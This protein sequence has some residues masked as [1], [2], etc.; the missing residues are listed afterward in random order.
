MC[1]QGQ[2]LR[3]P[4]STAEALAMAHAAADYLNGADLASLPGQAQA[5]ALI[6]LGRLAA[7][8]TAAH[9]R[10]VSAFAAGGGPEAD[11][12]YSAKTWLRHHTRITRGAA[13]AYTAW[14]RRLS[15]HPDV[16]SALAGGQLS[17]SWARQLC[18][19]TGRLPEQHRPAADEIL[20][21]AVRT[22]AALEDLAVLAEAIY[23]RVCADGPEADADRAFRDRAVYLGRTIGGA[24]RLEGDLTPGAAAALSAVLEALGAPSGP[25]DRRSLGQRNHDALAEGCRRLLAEGT[26]PARAG[27]G[28]RAE[29]AISLRQLRSL[30]GADAAE[31]GWVAAMT[32]GSGTDRTDSTDSTADGD[33]PYSGTL[34]GAEAAAAACDA[35]VVPVVYGHVDTGALEQMADLIL[36]SRA[37]PC[38]TGT[39]PPEAGP[40]PAGTLA[41]ATR[42]RLRAAL[43]RWAIEVLSGPGG[44]AAHLRRATLGEELASISLPLDVGQAS[45]I[46]PAHI[47]RAVIAR[48]RHCRFPG[49]CDQPAAACHV[50]HLTARRDGGRTALHSLILLC[51]FHHLV[52]VHSWGW[53]ITLNADGTTTATGPDGRILRSHDPPG[54]VA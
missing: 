28:T 48:D 19:W 16:A 21:R 12:A 44:L 43:L 5:E 36:A 8:H 17:P 37:A 11:A 15:S 30:P 39:L 23:R 46:I 25:E 41:P 54:E 10:L 34:T 4:A 22:G 49:G 40:P 13:G 9:A 14:A 24:G 50:H 45:H 52:A 6:G 27:Q 38:P 20:L 26:L 42:R 32:G 3:V 33:F 29:V 2:P 35:A 31:D 7:K 53:A 47:R 1:D 51:T 18:D